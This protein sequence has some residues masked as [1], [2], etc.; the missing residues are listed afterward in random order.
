MRNKL[1]PKLVVSTWSLA[2]IAM[3]GGLLGQF[4]APDLAQAAE[5]GAACVSCHEKPVASFKSSYHAKIWQGKNDCQSCH[6]ATDKHTSDP[7][8]QSVVSFGKGGGRSAD[9]LSKMCL[10]CHKKA[11]HLAMWDMGAHKKNDVNCAACHDIHSP[12]AAVKQPTVCFSCHKDV[13]SDANKISHHPIIEGKV[14]CS[15]CHNTH[16]SQAK[17]MINAESNN[18]LCYKCHADKRGPYAWE[19]QPVS[20]DCMI[21]HTPHGSRHETLLVEKIVNL[22]QDCHDVPT[23]THVGGLNVAA[24]MFQSAQTSSRRVTARG[25]IECHHA[26]HGSSNLARTRFLK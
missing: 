9:E 3:G 11:A 24:N 12:R 15:D 1:L 13:R 26:I 5:L 25:C 8:K 18:Q 20:E 22:C 2:M 21:C 19:H 10:G 7:S 4:L 23:S 6:G 14:K 17:H 16:G